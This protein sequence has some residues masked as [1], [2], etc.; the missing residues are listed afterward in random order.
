MVFL[1]PVYRNLLL[2]EGVVVK[3]RKNQIAVMKL[4]R[5]RRRKIPEKRMPKRKKQRS[6][7][8]QGQRLQLPVCLEPKR[9]YPMTL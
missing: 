1:L 5:K 9:N 3:L 7:K 2:S 6:R 8:R 4:L